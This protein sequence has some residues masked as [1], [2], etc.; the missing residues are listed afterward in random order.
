MASVADQTLF[1]CRW[2]RA[3]RETTAACVERLRLYGVRLSGFVVTGTDNGSFNL[4][5]G[6][7]LTRQEARLIAHRRQA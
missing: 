5:C 6:A 3:S 4:L 7:Q 2:G 1:V